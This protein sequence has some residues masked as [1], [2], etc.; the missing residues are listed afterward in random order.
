[1][2]DWLIVIIAGTTLG[3]VLVYLIARAVFHKLRAIRRRRISPEH[4]EKTA[5]VMD[6]M[7]KLLEQQRTLSNEITDSLE[8]RAQELRELIRQADETIA[9][10]AARVSTFSTPQADTEHED[11]DEEPL[12]EVGTARAERA[13]L[14]GTVR[15]V[16]PAEFPLPGSRLSSED[17]QRLIY[18][19]ADSGMDIH[20][21][22]REMK[23]G[24]G[25]VKLVLSLRQGA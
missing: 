4:V 16:S 21:I 11:E 10:L 9:R 1:M 25:E 17:K 23:I 8:N 14:F 12:P 22:A 2:R 6:A 24:K 15:S 7:T 13:A 20:E 18:E 3:V 19:Y 5:T